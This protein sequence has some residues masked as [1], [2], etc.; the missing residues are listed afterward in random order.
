MA[1][2][3][4]IKGG[5]VR[6]LLETA[7]PGTFAAPCG[8]TSK[9]VTLSKGLEDT[10]GVSC[11]EPDAVSW[12]L[13]D[14]VSLSISVS[15]EGVLATESVATWIAAWKS[16]DSVNCKIEVEMPVDTLTFTGAMHVESI[17][18]NAP[19]GR[20][21]TANISMQSDGTMTDATAATV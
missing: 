18:W 3:T 4:T 20:R 7:T 9:S 11:D 14:A 2:A 21:V 12:L 19:N 17:E 6:V 15:G 5:K 8:F 16:V 1:D 13:R 10:Q